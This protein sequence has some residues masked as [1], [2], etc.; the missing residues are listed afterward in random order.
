[1]IRERVRKRIEEVIKD[2][3]GVE[4]S[5]D[6]N[7]S[8]KYG[9]FATNVAFVLA[10]TLKRNPKEI[11]EE[12][13]GKLDEPAFE[14]VE[15]LNGF[16]NVYISHEGW[17]KELE[18]AL[19]ENYGK[20]ELGKGERVLIEFVSANPTGPLNVANA[21]AAAF[22]DA[23]VRLFRFCG[24]RADAEFYVNDCG[25]QFELLGESIEARLK[26]EEPPE[27]GYKG[28][29]I[30]EI[31]EEIKKEGR[32]KEGREFFS[33]Y[34]VERIVEWQRKALERYRVHFDNWVFE[35]EIRK[36][37][38]VEE[39]LEKLKDNIVEEE[40]AKWFLSGKF[41]DRREKRVVVKKDGSYTYLLPDIAYH[42]NKFERGYELLIDLLG[43]DHIDQ[44]PSIRAGLAALGYPP[45]KLEVIIIQWVNLIQD[46]QKIKMAKRK[47]K[48]V[49]MEWL[50]DEV[51]VDAARFFFL[52][53][54]AS[55][56]LDFDLDL[57][58]EESQRNPVY[59]VQYAHARIHNV[60][61]FAKSKG[62]DPE[63][64]G[65]LSNLKEKEEVELIKK[66]A[67]FPEIIQDAVRERDPTRIPFYLMD[68][69][70]FYHSFYQHHRI[71]GSPYE[72]ERLA[73]CRGTINVLKKGLELI[74]V[75][76]PLR[77]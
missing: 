42:L 69:A 1:M 26:G 64:K 60:I 71:V 72:K 10:K 32:E 15:A 13:A 17:I 55:S 22:G 35:S 62:I 65:D 44:V 53:R 73:L 45:E 14:R 25:R 16:I 9:D 31:A 36:K 67:E 49:D 20:A 58:K 27:D 39:V 7:R 4:V 21:R 63:D 29:Y 54:K 30:V 66:I 57:A 18:S 75:S 68:L 43:P 5:P 38:K 77:M 12:I 74:G 2:L 28:D 50:L 40:G 41:G 51:G 48:F 23:L 61:E 76:A 37:G 24:Y 19:E 46:G 47:G 8:E 33:R 6:V 70:S 56:P 59:Y 11:A 3:Y 34:A 52:M